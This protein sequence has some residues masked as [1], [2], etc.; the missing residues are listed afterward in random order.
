MKKV[1][2]EKKSRIVDDT[3]EHPDWEYEASSTHVRSWLAVPLVAGNIG[4][5]L[6]S[7]TKREAAA[8]TEENRQ[9]AEALAA[10][11]AVAIQNARLYESVQAQIQEVKEM[12]ALAVQNEKMSALGRL[13]ASLAH[14]INNP[15]QAMQGCLMLGMEK[16]AVAD[17]G[18][19]E[20]YLLIV[21]TEIERVA[22]IIQHLRDFYR[23][24]P[25][26]KQPTDL[27]STL[28]SVLLLAQKQLEHRSVIVE[29]TAAAH[30]PTLLASPDQLKQVFLNLILNAV[31]AMPDGGD[32]KLH[33]SL[34]TMPHITEL[35]VP[36]VRVIFQNSGEPIDAA[37]LP[38]IFEPFF[39]TKEQGSG[40]GLSIS[41]GIIEAHGG[42]ITVTSEAVNGTIFTILLPVH[43]W[44][45][46]DPDHVEELFPGSKDTP[47]S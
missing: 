44:F 4:I 25:E 12:Q 2:A 20:Q 3:Q 23:I 18:K 39:T 35:T 8:F 47:K 38:Y 7:L 13:M 42:Q 28:D 15:I 21:Q 26:Q 6:Y 43:G 16:L 22:R 27:E 17:L 14:E 9:W 10:Q 30:L 46:F 41:Y 1:L 36:A 31:D 24:T 33:T 32:L 29:R 11:A 19:A 34:T 45:G 5:G 37:A 40:L